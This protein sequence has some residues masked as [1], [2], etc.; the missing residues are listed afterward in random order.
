MGRFR[1][2]KFESRNPLVAAG[3]GDR[4]VARVPEQTPC[5][6]AADLGARPAELKGINRTI[7]K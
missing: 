6:R 7:R 2:S 4:H 3:E 1:N 5:Y